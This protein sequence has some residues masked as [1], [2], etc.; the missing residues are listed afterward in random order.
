MSEPDAI[1]ALRVDGRVANAFPSV[2][3]SVF[4]FAR[5]IALLYALILS[6]A[7]PFDLDT[8]Q[9]RAPRV[10]IESMRK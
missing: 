4:D 1:A 2:R 10:V 8:R 5:I 9:N 6:F 7:G 3:A